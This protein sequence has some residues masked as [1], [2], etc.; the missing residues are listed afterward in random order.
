[1]ARGIDKIKDP[2]ESEKAMRDLAKD[3]ATGVSGYED[4][5]P[6]QL[7]RSNLRN[8]NSNERVGLVL[9]NLIGKYGTLTGTTGFF[10]LAGERKSIQ[11]KKEGLRDYEFSV[12][13]PE[14]SKEATRDLIGRHLG[15][16]N[17]VRGTALGTRMYQGNIMGGSQ[18]FK[19]EEWKV[20]SNGVS[21]YDFDVFEKGPIV[22]RSADTSVIE[23][24]RA[25]FGKDK[26]GA[27]KVEKKMILEYV[28][29]LKSR[30][31][32]LEEKIK[33]LIALK[34]KVEE[35]EETQKDVNR[36]CRERFDAYFQT[37]AGSLKEK[38]GKL[39]GE[40]IKQMRDR[41]AA[42]NE[43]S[44]LGK[45]SFRKKGELDKVI[46]DKTARERKIIEDIDFLQKA[47]SSLYGAN[48]IL[49]ENPPAHKIGNEM[50]SANQ[51][52]GKLKSQLESLSRS[53]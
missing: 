14:K 44:R 2:K 1:M 10:E 30:I 15:T 50:M 48:R 40:R 47:E 37:D 6:T 52:G 53:E 24:A 21:K 26:E 5:E 49:K 7:A 29:E 45:L 39:D 41:E 18:R 28:G 36:K 38:I 25:S 32:G 46:S 51:E 11:K 9:K 33:E 8:L 16:L 20:F 19:D 22:P 3:I 17:L 12:D 4:V 35:A 31:S 23:K 34:K 42:E 13:D 27:E 43:K